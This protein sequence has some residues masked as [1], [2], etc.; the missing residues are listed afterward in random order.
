MSEA[1]PR[2]IE[3]RPVVLEGQHVRLEPLAT[4]HAA[5]LANHA[6]PDI[7]RFSGA[8][9]PS[10]D[11]FGFKR[12]I[13]SLQNREDVVPFALVLRDTGEAIGMTTYMEIRPAHLGL[14]IGATW[15]SKAHQGTFVNPEAKFL[16]LEHAFEVIGCERV[17]IKCD[18]RNYQSQAAILKLGAYF[19]GC[20]RR[21]MVMPD[22]YVRDTMMYSILPD[23]WPDVKR[24]LKAR[25]ESG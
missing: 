11:E 19:E 5:N 4:S 15:I 18:A 6:E 21:H 10:L 2:S 8:K 12:H 9:P 3:V 22:G 14:E 7:F 24:R 16:L 20:L 25:L 17:Q 23:E 13:A 1:P